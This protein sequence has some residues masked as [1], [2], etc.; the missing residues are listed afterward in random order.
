MYAAIAARLREL[1]HQSYLAR[2]VDGLPTA[3][4]AK[5]RR[6]T[7]ITNKHPIIKE[8]RALC[9]GV[10]ERTAEFRTH[11]DLSV[12]SFRTYS[13][14]FPDPALEWTLLSAYRKAPVGT[15]AFNAR[16]I[17]LVAPARP[18]LFSHHGYLEDDICPEGVADMVGYWAEDRILG[19][20]TIFDR[21]AEERT[22]Q[23]PP[24]FLLPCG[25]Q[26]SDDPVLSDTRRPIP[27]H[28][29][30]FFLAEDCHVVS[31]P[32]PVLGDKDNRVRVDPIE[33]VL[34]RHIYRDVWDR[35]PPGREDI[36]LFERRPQDEIDYPE[37]R[38][39]IFEINRGLGIPLP[40]NVQ[41]DEPTKRFK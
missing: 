32:L 4:V 2:I 14:S 6:L 38:F 22:P 37:H 13:K 17:E 29:G 34:R 11:V 18:T 5:A 31:C 39:I 33:A 26:E 24:E 41:L 30:F 23:H 15:Q 21:L 16:L 36:S 10:L 9:P 20:V 8:H 27:I 35:R 19:A 40:P 3:D 7:E 1:A 25:T 12:L 28:A